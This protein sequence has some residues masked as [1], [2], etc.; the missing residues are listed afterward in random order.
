MS[1]Q[2]KKISLLSLICN[3]MFLAAAAQNDKIQFTHA[4][5]L[6]GALNSERAYDVLKY[7]ISFTPDFDNKFI[8]GK[9]T[10]T[11]KDS[12]FSIQANNLH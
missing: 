2:A 4:D 7:D 3:I 8:Q 10:I 5:T 12:S 11:Y 6:R 9:N 1:Q